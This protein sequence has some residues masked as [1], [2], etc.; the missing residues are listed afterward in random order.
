MKDKQN[1]TRLKSKTNSYL[2]LKFEIE[3]KSRALMIF[4]SK[5]GGGGN[6]CMRE[7]LGKREMGIRGYGQYEMENC[8]KAG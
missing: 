4:V 8:T 1:E 2:R 5:N 3:G 7:R 6:W